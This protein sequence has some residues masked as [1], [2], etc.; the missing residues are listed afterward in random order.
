[1]VMPFL[2]ELGNIS[3]KTI[4]SSRALLADHYTD[5]RT[6]CASKMLRKPVGCCEN[7]LDEAHNSKPTS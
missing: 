4:N 6:R 3:V 5:K 2:A 1:M 7:D